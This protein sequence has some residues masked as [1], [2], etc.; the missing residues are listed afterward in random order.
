MKSNS[1]TKAILNNSVGDIGTPRVIWFKTVK[2]WIG[3]ALTLV[4]FSALVKLGMWQHQRGD[5]KVAL[6]ET[7]AQRALLPAAEITSLSLPLAKQSEH[8]Y[9]KWIGLPVS[10]YLVPS[11]YLYYLDNQTL[12]GVVGYLVY[13]LMIAPSQQNQRFLVELGFIAGGLDRRHLPVVTP[14]SKPVDVQG[15]LYKKIDSPLGSELHSERFVDEHYS[16]YR[17]QNLNL[18]LLSEA[19]RSE[20]ALTGADV[21][22][23]GG[24]L[25]AWVIQPTDNLTD[26]PHPWKPISMNSAKHYGYSFQ[27][28]TMAAVFALVVMV[29]FVRWRSTS[30]R[31]KNGNRG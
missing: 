9:L 25:S 23:I 27:W 18:A 14:I 29:A 16:L 31:V 2:F 26:Y 11:P 6:E 30:G 24:E 15:R 19:L 20:Q 12:D 21:E 1:S 7:L 28:F 22:T 13:Q 5:E 17:I 8:N 10:A 4:V 3:L